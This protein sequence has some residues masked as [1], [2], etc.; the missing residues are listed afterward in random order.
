MAAK[1]I[2]KENAGIIVAPGSISEMIS[3]IEKLRNDPALS[4]EMGKNG[5]RY[6]EMNFQ[7]ENIV[8]SV[9]NFIQI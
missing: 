8:K 9:R 2:V 7:I 5:R 6:A 3:A 4:L 1:I